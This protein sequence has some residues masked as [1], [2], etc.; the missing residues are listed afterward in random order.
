MARLIR[1]EARG[2]YR[3]DPQDFPKD[4]PIYICAC[5]LSRNLPFCDGAHKQCG[6]EEEGKLYRYGPDGR[7]EIDRA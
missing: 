4:K 6:A 2:P 5:G 1:H 7:E 3:I